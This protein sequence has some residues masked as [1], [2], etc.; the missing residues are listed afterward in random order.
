MAFLIRL[1]RYPAEVT[2]QVSAQD[3]VSGEEYH[4]GDLEQL[5]MFLHL[6]T[7]LKKPTSE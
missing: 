6:Q 1:W 2:W 5:F 3:A 7:K 4:F